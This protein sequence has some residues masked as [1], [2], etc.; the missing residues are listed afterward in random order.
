D[1]RCVLAAEARPLFERPIPGELEV[2]PVRVAQVDGQVGAVVGQ[3]PERDPCIDE[4]TD[5]LG[6]LRARGEVERDVVEARHTVRLRGAGPA[7]P[8]GCGGPPA[9][10]QVLNPRWWW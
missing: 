7:R 8:A 9:D 1:R 3:L 6:E 4:A 10:F 2:V 5:G